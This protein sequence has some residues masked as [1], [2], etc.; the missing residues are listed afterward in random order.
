MT[1]K[2]KAAKITRLCDKA[3]CSDKL[4]KVHF[5]QF[6]ERGWH[7]HPP[8]TFFDWWSRHP[9]NV[10]AGSSGPVTFFN[11][12]RYYAQFC[13]MRELG[14]LN[15]TPKSLLPKQQQQTLA[16]REREQPT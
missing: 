6:V 3:G 12:A 10:G 8:Q 11:A 5:A 9:D 13:E 16:L 15:E 14:L 2:E 1:P 7:P 4:R